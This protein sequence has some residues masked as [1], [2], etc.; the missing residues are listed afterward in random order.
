M[1]LTVWRETTISFAVFNSVILIVVCP[2]KD[3]KA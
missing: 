3:H 2:K 1:F